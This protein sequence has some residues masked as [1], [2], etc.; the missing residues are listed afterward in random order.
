MLNSKYQISI[1]LLIVAMYVCYISNSS[2]QQLKVF[3]QEQFYSIQYER[4][5]GTDNFRNLTTRP[6]I[7]SDSVS[8]IKYKTSKPLKS[9]NHKIFNHLLTD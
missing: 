3:P 8:S 2:A 4:E 9:F 6:F 7:F 5:Y 1:W